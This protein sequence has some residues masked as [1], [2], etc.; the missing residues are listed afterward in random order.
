MRK[1]ENLSEEI[2]YRRRNI[3]KWPMMYGGIQGRN[4]LQQTKDKFD[5]IYEEIRKEN[6]K[7]TEREKFL[8]DE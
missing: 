4:K 7:R 8:S 2:K 1:S 5:V 6:E 3:E